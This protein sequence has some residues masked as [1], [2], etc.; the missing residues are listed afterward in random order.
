[1]FALS[2]RIMKCEFCWDAGLEL[3]IVAKRLAALKLTRPTMGITHRGLK[4]WAISLKWLKKQEFHSI[5]TFMKLKTYSLMYCKAF[6]RIPLPAPQHLKCRQR[7]VFDQSGYNISYQIS[8]RL[9]YF[10]QNYVLPSFFDIY[11]SNYSW[12]RMDQQ[13]KWSARLQN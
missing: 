4:L 6:N 7:P 12:S 3:K 8:L 5:T 10:P 9:K 2:K 13:L 1:M 11:I